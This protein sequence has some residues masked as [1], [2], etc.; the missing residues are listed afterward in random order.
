MTLILFVLLS[1]AQAHEIE[2]NWVHMSDAPTWLTR[3]RVEK[4]VNHIQTQMEWDIR[5]VEVIWYHDQESFQKSHSLGPLA[6]AVSRKPDNIIRLGPKVTNE[7]FDAVFGHE[8]V[9]IISYQKYKDAIPP[10][11]E[12]GLAN[13]LAK[14][15]K[16][17]YH[18]LAEHPFPKDVRS[19]THPYAGDADSTRYDYMAS[20]ALAEMIAKKC[21]LGNL[22]Q[23]SVGEKM[24][25]Y[26]DTYCEIKDLNQAFQKWVKDHAK[27]G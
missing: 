20:Q 9:H 24:E 12:E 2:T 11:L 13:Y 21:D 15:G 19:L 16:V 14:Q 5:K 17:N 7:N 27:A 22:L 8:L 25:P 3:N 23:L 1:W 26:L 4:I 6:I 18:W 10:W